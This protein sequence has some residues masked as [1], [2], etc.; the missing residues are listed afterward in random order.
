MIIRRF[1][2]SVNPYFLE[3]SFVMSIRTNADTDSPYSLARAFALDI[4][5][6]DTRSVSRLAFVGRDCFFKVS[7]PVFGQM[8]E[9][10]HFFTPARDDVGTGAFELLG[11]VAL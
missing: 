11:A 10:E 6:S 8:D 7:L 2:G 4:K 1:S 9:L 5:D 3:I